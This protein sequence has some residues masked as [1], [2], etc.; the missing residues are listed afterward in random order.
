MHLYRHLKLTGLADEFRAVFGQFQVAVGINI[1][2][3]VSVQQC[4]TQDGMQRAFFL[5]AGGAEILQVIVVITHHLGCCVAVQY[6][7]DMLRFMFLVHLL[8][9]LQCQLQQLACI[10]LLVG[11]ATIVAV[12][13]LVLVILFAEIVEQQLTPAYGAL[14]VTLRLEKQLV[15]DTYLF[16]RFVFLK[17]S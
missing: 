8:D 9:G 7:Y 2:L 4:L 3:D 6:I 13:A 12:T 14:G 10:H 1:F 17:S 5:I 15:S 16:G 11:L